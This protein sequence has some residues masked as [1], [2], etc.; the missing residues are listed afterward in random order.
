MQHAKR[1]RRIVICPVW[2]YHNFPHYL[3]NG[4]TFGNKTFIENKMCFDFLYN[5]LKYFSF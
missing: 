1:M 2:L 3:I 5:F 4:L